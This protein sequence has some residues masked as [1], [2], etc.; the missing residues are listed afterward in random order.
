M[1]RENEGGFD[2]KI[3]VECEG[4]SKGFLLGGFLS[5]GEFG[6]KFVGGFLTLDLR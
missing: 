6:L 2:F 5:R 1:V 4:V 3:D